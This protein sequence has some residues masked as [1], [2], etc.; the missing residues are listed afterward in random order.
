MKNLRTPAL[1]VWM[2]LYSLFAPAQHQTIP[3][4]EPD[5]NK[6]RLFNN[7]PDNIPV[8][9]NTLAGLL[10]APVGSTISTNLAS[11]MPFTFEGQVVSAASKYG[12][13]IRSV[14]IRSTNFNGARL[15]LSKI[16]NEDG[17]SSYTG[18]IIS[19][20]HGDLYVLQ[21]RDG[22]FALVKKGFYDVVNE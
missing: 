7:L 15:T 14:V 10:N 1:F 18:R 19:L 4:N 16:T 11:D 2:I 6:P 13:S 5:N 22:Q 3:L 21:N 9:I 17:I 8:N 12:G 20:Q